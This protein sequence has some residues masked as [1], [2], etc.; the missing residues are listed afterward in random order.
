MMNELHAETVM[1]FRRRVRRTWTTAA[2]LEVIGAALI[3]CE[4]GTCVVGPRVMHMFPETKVDVATLDV[5]KLANESYP[6]WQ[7]V[8]GQHACPSVADLLPYSDIPR[9]NDPWGSGYQ[10]ICEAHRVR[11]WSLG[12]DRTPNT[13]DDIRSDP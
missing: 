2:L 12:E 8:H 10:L 3:L 1:P 6:Q 13:N 9:V 11:V 7:R 5:Q 4:V